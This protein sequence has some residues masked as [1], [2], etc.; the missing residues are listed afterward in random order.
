M[1][2][3]LIADDPRFN[4]RAET[5]RHRTDGLELLDFR[6]ITV[7][8][9][10]VSVDLAETEKAMEFAGMFHQLIPLHLQFVH[11]GGHQAQLLPQILVLC[12]ESMRL[13]GHESVGNGLIQFRETEEKDRTENDSYESELCSGPLR[14]NVRL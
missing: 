9:N 5:G 4:S 2:S 14:F 7:A 8:S 11:P 6:K 1:N 10:R 3:L 12:R 13:A